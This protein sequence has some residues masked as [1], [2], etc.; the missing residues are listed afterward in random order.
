[1]NRGLKASEIIDK[2]QFLIKEYGDL[3]VFKERTGNFR[4]VYCIEYYKNENHIEIL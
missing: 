3:E 1:M 4:P 2:L